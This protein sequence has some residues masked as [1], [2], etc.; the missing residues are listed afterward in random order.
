MIAGRVRVLLVGEE[1]VKIR[2]LL[3]R[4][5][6]RDDDMVQSSGRIHRTT[7]GLRASQTMKVALDRARA[8]R[9]DWSADTVRLGGVSNGS[10][11]KSEPEFLH[12]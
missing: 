5:A 9:V 8:A 6:E 2:L 11:E 7:V 12:E 10:K 4:R 3:G 1:P